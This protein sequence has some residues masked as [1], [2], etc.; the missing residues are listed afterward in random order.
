[1]EHRNDGPLS[2]N[3]QLCD[4]AVRLLREY[5][6]RGPTKAKAMIND[7]SVMILLGD[8][9][10]RGERRL[11]DTG[12]AD[13]VLQ[14]RHDYQLTMG[15]EL[16]AAVEDVV[17]RRVIAFMSQN[18]I[19]PDLAVEIFVLQPDRSAADPSTIADSP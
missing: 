18:H 2:V 12:K 14:L 4:A 3:S 6:G 9:L 7:D 17:G 1:M 10:T 15:D 16:V 19:D 5:T 13:R 11:A 8:T